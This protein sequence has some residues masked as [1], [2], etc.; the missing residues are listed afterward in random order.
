M[1]TSIVALSPI[2]FFFII[3]TLN[4][5]LYTNNIYVSFFIIPKYKRIFLRESTWSKDG[6]R[7]LLKLLTTTYT[8]CTYIVIN[9]LLCDVHWFWIPTST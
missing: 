3:K 4:I 5:F 1:N 7:G 8:L 9:V 2:Y 6:K